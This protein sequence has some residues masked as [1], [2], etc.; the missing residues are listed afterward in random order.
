MV[1]W[2]TTS[3]KKNN[4]RART[5]AN[6]HPYK[7]PVYAVPYNFSFAVR[8]RATVRRRHTPNKCVL[9]KSHKIAEA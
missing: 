9:L 3:P 7:M 4:T 6:T 1:S 5:G 2:T 8:A